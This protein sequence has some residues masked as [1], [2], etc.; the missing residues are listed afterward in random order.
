MLIYQKYKK[1]HKDYIKTV[2]LKHRS[3]VK[4]T[5]GAGAPE[6]GEPAPTLA[7]ITVGI[8]HPGLTNHLP[9]VNICKVGIAHLGLRLL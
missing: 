4:L 3:N 7:K 9:T 8:A 2:A 1:V 6:Q 5:R